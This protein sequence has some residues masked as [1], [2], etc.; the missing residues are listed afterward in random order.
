MATNA[1]SLIMDMV[2]FV[3]GFSLWIINLFPSGSCTT[4]M[5]Q[6]GR[7]E[8]L[9]RKGHVGLFQ[10]LDRLV[11]I[12]HLERRACPLIRRRPALADVRDRKRVFAQPIFDPLP[13]HQ[14]SGTFRPRTPS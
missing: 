7:L 14:S 9:G 11:E 3:S 8:W 13:L 10:S 4:A 12:F 5:W 2:L 1:T 6:H